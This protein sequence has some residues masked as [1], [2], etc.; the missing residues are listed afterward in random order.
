M[1]INKNKYHIKTTKQFDKNL[2]KAIKQGKSI[3][4]I[5]NV[6]ELLSN[7]TQLDQKYKNHKLTDSKYYKDCYECHIE[8]DW[9]LI[10][11]YI[12]NDIVLLLVN[13]GSHSNLF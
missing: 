8:P 7:D 6:V 13:T 1:T 11:Q 9:L 5:K 10:Y 12:E 2:K 4:K 3:N